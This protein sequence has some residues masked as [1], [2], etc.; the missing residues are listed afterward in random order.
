MATRKGISISG[1]YAVH[2]RLY[3]FFI[4]VLYVLKNRKFGQI[5]FILFENSTTIQ[6]G[7]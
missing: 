4:Y 1:N 7:V 5:V 3:A 2:P 6:H